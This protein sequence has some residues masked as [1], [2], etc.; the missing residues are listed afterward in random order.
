MA[1]FTHHA[2]YLPNSK[3]TP[4]CSFTW[5]SIV[6]LVIFSDLNYKKNRTL[7]FRNTTIHY[8]ENI[9]YM[10]KQHRKCFQYS[11]VCRTPLQVQINV[12]VD[13]AT[14]KNVLTSILNAGQCKIP[15]CVLYVCFYMCKLTQVI[16]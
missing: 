13:R 2:I 3:Q 8:S 5:S 4:G 9:Q 10:Q 6:T 11:L 7:D 1:F 12:C 14:V 15:V 16:Y